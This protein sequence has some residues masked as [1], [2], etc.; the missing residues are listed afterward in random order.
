M[1]KGNGVRYIQEF[2][3][4]STFLSNK[5][6]IISGKGYVCV[7]R[8]LLIRLLEKNSYD[9]ADGKL[10]IWKQLH[11][12]DTDPERYTKKISSNGKRIRV[13]KI[14]MTVVHTL[15]DMFKTN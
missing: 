12:I 6:E 3:A 7:P 8:E 10:Q 11:W 1:E 4:L 14:D 9:T 5:E 13:I 15:D 2:V